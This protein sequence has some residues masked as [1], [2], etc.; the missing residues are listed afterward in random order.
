[1]PLTSLLAIT[2][3]VKVVLKTTTVVFN[4]LS[5]YD[6]S[7]DTNEAVPCTVDSTCTAFVAGAVCRTSICGVDVQRNVNFYVRDYAKG[8]A[9]FPVPCDGTL[10]SAE[11][12]GGRAAAGGGIEITERHV[13]APFTMP[14]SCPTPDTLPTLSWTSNLSSPA[15]ATPTVYAGMGGTFNVSVTGLSYPWSRASWR[16]GY[17]GQAPTLVT[18]ALVAP[19]PVPATTEPLSFT[20]IF[21]LDV[22]LRTDAA[23]AWWYSPPATIVTPVGMGSFPF[24]GP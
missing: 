6:G 13:A 12:I 7:T 21:Y 1:M 2:E 18:N 9:E 11:V 22:S 8:D 24:P 15:L 4:P 10:Y 17:T 3:Q 5:Q 16:V 20:G 19:F 14:A 23:T